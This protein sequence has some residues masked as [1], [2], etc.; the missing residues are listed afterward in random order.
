VGPI[1]KPVTPLM[2]PPLGFANSWAWKSQGLLLPSLSAFQLGAVTLPGEISVEL[3]P[4]MKFVGI[5][6][7]GASPHPLLPARPCPWGGVRARFP[8]RYELNRPMD[9]AGRWDLL[10]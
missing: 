5:L 4:V 3:D 9:S 8:F 6:R 10:P 1:R 7:A 2:R